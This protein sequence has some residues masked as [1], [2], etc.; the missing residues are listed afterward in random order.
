MILTPIEEKLTVA[1]IGLMLRA[2]FFGNLASR[3]K[4]ICADSWCQTAA[5]DGK[6][7]YYNSEF[8]EKLSVKN[9]EFLFGHEILHCAFEHFSR[10]GSRI[11]R[12]S[13]IAQDFA[14]NIILSDEKIG[15]VIDQVQICLDPQYRGLAWE[16]IYDMLMENV[17]E[18]SVE[19][20]MAGIDSLDDHISQDDSGSDDGD[21]DKE[22]SGRPRYSKEEWQAI[23][24]ELKEA[25]I[26]AHAAAAG[27]VP[28][29]IKRMIQDITEP[30]MNW[31]ELLQMNIQS[32]VR[33]NYSFS[34][35]SRK[36]WASGAILP[37]MIPEQTIDIAIALDMSGSI[38]QNE[39]SIFLGEVSGILAQYTDYSIDLF[40]YD[41]RV[42]NHIKITSENANDLLTYEPVGGGGTDYRCILEHLKDQNLVPKKL[43]NFTDLYVSDFVEELGEYCDCLFLVF[44]NE[45]STAPYGQTVHY[46]D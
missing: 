28:A 4:L 43:I 30:K 17:T 19:D 20:I 11:P 5:T 29:A 13:N 38:G 25:M 37:G 26:Q 39:I 7:F 6:H 34:R 1:R 21:G 41:T 32:I 9:L 23:R 46:T 2:S 45:S 33:S 44:G 14:V 18:L 42:Y 12:I 40:T 8:V 27:N 16:T 10:R 15:T 22:G 24:D 35:P 36:G 3:M 31:R